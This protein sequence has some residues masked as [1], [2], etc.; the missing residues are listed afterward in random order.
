MTL[1]EL[2][3]LM[4]KRWRLV[5]ALPLALALVTALYGYIFMPNV[6]TASTSVYVLTKAQSSSG[7]TSTDLS[8]SQMI[9][10]DVATLVKSARVQDLAAKEAGMSSLSGYKVSVESTTTTR[11]IT[12]SVSGTD[13]A[14]VAQVA[15][16][17]ASTADNIAQEVMD[18]QS[19]NVIDEARVPAS[20]SGPRRLMYT[21]VAFLA[22]LFLAIAIVVI[23]D[24]ANTRV[25]TSEEAAELLD[26]PVIGRI[27]SIRV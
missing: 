19:I 27:P 18:V 13:P 25:R 11:I 24:M 3:D 14:K 7:I 20:P 10:N 12:I 2:F 4:K 6:Y 21:A 8:A 1:L 16:Q 22:G 23:A 15:N 17:L 5:V 9:T 26:L